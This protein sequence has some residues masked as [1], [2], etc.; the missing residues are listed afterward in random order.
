[1]FM[2][3]NLTCLA[4]LSVQKAKAMLIFLRRQLKIFHHQNLVKSVLHLLLATLDSLRQY[5]LVVSGLLSAQPS[6]TLIGT[7][8]NPAKS[9]KPLPILDQADW[10][11]YNDWPNSEK[12]FSPPD[13]FAALYPMAATFR[14]KWTVPSMDSA[15]TALNN[16]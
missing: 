9:T 10:A 6:H 11:V 3:Y 4:H 1:M 13:N 8:K 7:K 2:V 12:L 5:I 14:K 15:I 16:Q